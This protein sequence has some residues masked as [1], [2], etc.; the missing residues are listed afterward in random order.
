MKHLLIILL[1]FGR[2]CSAATVGSPGYPA[3][4][5]LCITETGETTFRSDNNG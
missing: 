4:R 1:L 2:I 5:T 3:G